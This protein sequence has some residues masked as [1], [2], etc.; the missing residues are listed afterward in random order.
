M[1]RREP[2]R[3]SRGAFP[4]SIARLAGTFAQDV[5][6]A[7]RLLRREPTFS[8][9]ALAT[10]S[11]GIGMHTAIFSVAYGVLWRPLPMR[12]PTA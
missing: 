9:A 8:V 4:T 10:L 1:S 11:L 3:T 2:A 7:L 6:L 5:R 12:R